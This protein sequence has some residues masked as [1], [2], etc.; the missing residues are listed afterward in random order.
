M[1]A[2]SPGLRRT[3]GNLRRS[4]RRTSRPAPAALAGIREPMSRVFGLDRG[5][6]IDRHYIEEFL[7]SHSALIR[8][9]TLEVGECTYS[10]RFGAGRV[11]RAEALVFEGPAGEGRLLGDLTDPAGL[12]ESRYDCFVCTQTFNFIYDVA[13]AVRG[14]HRVLKPGGTLLATVAGISQVSRWDF[15]RWGDFWRFTPLALERRIGEVFGSELEVRGRGNLLAATA[16]LHGLAVQDLPDAAALD[17]D[18][19]DYPVVVTA[20]ARRES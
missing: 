4:L 9:R 15:E 16:L 14:A 8:G 6:P 18:D 2:V 19:P 20:V 3:L 10:L 12:P 1:E 7:A 13:A 5:T 11:E 17:A